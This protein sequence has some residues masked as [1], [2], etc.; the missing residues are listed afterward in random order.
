M[1]E[2]IV[3]A[4]APRIHWCLC[5]VSAGKTRSRLVETRIRFKRLG[6]DDISMYLNSG[7]WQGK[8]GGY[9]IQGLAGCFVS[10]LTGSYSNVVGLPLY[11]TM[12]L[13]KGHGLAP[14]LS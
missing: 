14:R 13:L 11:E 5:V 1:F 12:N 7:E 9:A 2:N 10:Q 6:D 4:F 8:A 3:G